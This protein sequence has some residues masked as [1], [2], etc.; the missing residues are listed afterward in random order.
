MLQKQTPAQNPKSLATCTFY[1]GKL[2][3]N[4]K[5]KYDQVDSFFYQE[6]YNAPGTY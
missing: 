4:V 3:I 2:L 6:K 1:Y 5:C